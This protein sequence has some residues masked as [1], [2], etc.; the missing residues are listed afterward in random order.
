MYIGLVVIIL[1]A[2]LV[3]LYPCLYI[4]TISD[5]VSSSPTL[6]QSS[7]IH[8]L[9]ISDMATMFPGSQYTPIMQGNISYFIPQLRSEGYIES[10]TSIF[11]LQTPK[12]YNGTRF[13]AVI[14]SYILLLA[15]QT[16]A[17]QSLGSM[18]FS[19]NVNQVNGSVV[20]NTTKQGRT[21]S[22]DMHTVY[23]AAVFN[24]SIARMLN[25][26]NTHMPDFQYA[27]IFVYN[28]T[29]DAVYVNS[30]VQANNYSGVSTALAEMLANKII[31]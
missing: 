13:P 23:S 31:N 17:N 21:I 15:N 7:P 18:F 11:S 1:A 26:T 8:N 19:N 24:S 4:Y 25:I 14:V 27:S 10:S 5:H 12:E 16:D 9:N 20:Y 3:A 2:L 22:I 30:Y 28:N 29:V 6:S